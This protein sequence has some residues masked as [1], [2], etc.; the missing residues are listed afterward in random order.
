MFS[1]IAGFLTAIILMILAIGGLLPIDPTSRLGKTAEWF[2]PFSGWV[3]FLIIASRSYFALFNAL[4]AQIGRD[5][6]YRVFHK[7]YERGKGLERADDRRI[8]WDREVRQALAHFCKPDQ[9][10]AYCQMTGRFD[11]DLDVMTPL[12]AKHLESA[13]NIISELLRIDFANALKP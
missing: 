5:R 2:R 12:E 8:H 3:A 6:A 7:L 4:N 10:R 1:G 9:L 11:V 13:R